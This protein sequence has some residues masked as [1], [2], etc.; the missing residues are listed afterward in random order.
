LKDRDALDA[1]A[2]WKRQVKIDVI[3]YGSHR[4]MP[5]LY[6]NLLG[7]G[8]RDPLLDRLKGVYR[9]YLYKNQILLNRV[10]QLLKA[11]DQAGIPTLALKGVA[12]IQCYYHERGL[13]PMEDADILVP[14]AKALESMTLL[15]KFGWQPVFFDRP[16][17]RIAIIHS[18]PFVNADGQQIDLHWH[19]FWECF[20]AHDDSDYW[21][22][23]TPIKINDAPTLAL[24]PTHELLH[25]CWH[26][27]RWNEVPPIRWVADAMAILEATHSQIDWHELIEKARRHHISLPLR[28]SLS[29]LK[30]LLNA[31]IP[32]SVVFEL[33]AIP[34]SALEQEGYAAMVNPR[35][36]PTTAKIVRLLYLDYLW[37]RSS[38]NS[39]S[40]FLTFAKFLQAKWN[41]PS[42][43]QV[44]VY[45]P[46]RF[47]KRGFR[48]VFRLNPQPGRPVS[49]NPGRQQQP[50]L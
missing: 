33:A 12:L 27:A 22:Q 45:I 29:Y 20:N 16:E 35:L 9:Y 46:L 4:M 11:F 19:P 17:T 5:Q 25:T 39:H 43:W 15:K 26:G 8:V 49:S 21:K 28:D 2:A 3:D 37:L 40:R 13:R 36:P 14:T 32:D 50:I 1:W 42:L 10:S 24:N 34:T 47:I 23:A 48:D 31:P 7:H 30:Q 6:R 41:L 38:T 18:T 44:P